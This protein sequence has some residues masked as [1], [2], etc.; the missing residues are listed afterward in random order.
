MIYQIDELPVFSTITVIIN[1][2]TCMVTTLAIFS[3]KRY[4]SDDV[5]VLD[6]SK[7]KNE[8]EYLE[9]LQTKEKFYLCKLPLQIHGKTIDFLFRALKADYIRLL[10]SDAELLSSNWIGTDLLG[11]GSVFGC[12]FFHEP[13][14]MDN[15]AMRGGKFHFYQERMYIPC[16][17]LKTKFVKQA[18]E[19][20]K[21]FAAKKVYNDF[22]RLPLLSHLLYFRF[23]FRFFQN[24]DVRLFRIFR[25]TYGEY[26]KPS[27]VY[28]DTG[29]EI[30]LY[31]KYQ[32][33]LDFIGYPM[34]YH[35]SYFSHYHGITRKILNKKDFNA[36]SYDDVGRIVY[37][38]LCS[39][40]HFDFFDFVGVAK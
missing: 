31:L 30:Y 40:Y 2:D 39:E 14:M 12:G 15:K 27:M 4:T 6:C 37:H 38:R 35:N 36:T 13:H 28:Y 9:K 22:P 8:I 7:D 32:K 21:T 25:H 20:G 18:L 26:F 19:A 16:V 5:L 33:G 17:L 24:H 34:K 23:A 29:A 11:K 3:A 1:V 10:D